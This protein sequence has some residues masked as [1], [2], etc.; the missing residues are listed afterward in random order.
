MTNQGPVPTVDA[1]QFYEELWA[2]IEPESSRR[3]LISALACFAAK[4][5]E[6]A[7]TREIAEG[8]GVS[9]S[10]LYVHYRS[11]E[12][13]L[14]EIIQ[15]GH[16][17]N[18]GAIEDAVAGGTTPTEALSA[19]VERFVIWHARF[20]TLARVCQ[21][22]LQSL[23]TDRVRA[24]GEIRRRFQRELERIVDAGIAAGEFQVVDAHGTAR[25]ILSLGIDV[26]RWFT[27]GGSLRPEDLAQLYVV[28]ALRM[29]GRL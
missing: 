20:H 10:A 28:L 23:D 12:E 11:K 22:E 1:E 29:V 15:I 25:A 3:L 7:S 4:G 9:P 13:L 14:F 8:A 5:F 24:V 17:R 27:D 21:Y 6:G 18:W 19:F 16:S 26:A 2:H